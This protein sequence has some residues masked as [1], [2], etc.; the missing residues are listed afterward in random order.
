[1]ECAYNSQPMA[2]TNRQANKQRRTLS[3]AEKA[4]RAKAAQQRQEAERARRERAA[5][6][7]K[8]FTVIVCVILVLALG[9]PT[10]ALSF[11][12]A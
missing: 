2:Q 6:T 9:I 5:R 3:Q 11:L 10:V 1:M 12:A 8:V 7:K 4:A